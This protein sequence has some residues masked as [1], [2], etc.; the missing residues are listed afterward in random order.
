MTSL[1]RNRFYRT[2]FLNA[3]YL[4]SLVHRQ[5]SVQKQCYIK[6]ASSSNVSA[7]S[8]HSLA[9]NTNHTILICKSRTAQKVKNGF[10]KITGVTLEKNK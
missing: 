1:K 6:Q 5:Q 4:Y 9:T 3:A 8:L 2:V 7:A 10:G